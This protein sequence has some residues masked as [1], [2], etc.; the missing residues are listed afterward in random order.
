MTKRLMNLVEKLPIYEDNKKIDA[1]LIVSSINRLY[2]SGFKSS[3]GIIFVTLDESYFVVDFRYY[4]SAL[5]QVKNM[6]VVLATDFKSEILDIIK[7]HGIK[8]ILLENDGITL[9][10]VLKF[11]K[12]VERTSVKFI[13]TKT[14]DDIIY[15][16]RAVKTED[17]IKNIKIA[18]EISERALNKLLPTIK[19]GMTEREIAFNLEILIR[20]EGADAISFDLIVASGKNSAIP[21]A[22]PSNKRVENG[23]FITIDM[24]AVYNGYHSD[25]TRTVA[26]GKVS[27]KKKLIYETVLHAQ[28]KAMKAI[29]PNVFCREVDDIARKFIYENGYEGCF[30]HA[31]GHGVGLEI[32][33][34]PFLS[35]RSE[36]VLKPGM[37]ITVEPGIY[38]K[39]EFGVRIEDM[40]LVTETGCENLTLAS[41]EL[42]IL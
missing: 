17:E 15:S 5:K 2:F 8:N 20:K 30:G 25:M 33:E 21:H 10:E 40:V 19:L 28:N 14:L 41:R 22:E 35:A 42:L 4:E 26:L 39:N 1:A 24:G 34:M 13:K 7:R 32:H 23:D 6:K 18:Q 38:L 11:E 27:E 31:L 12:L 37:I 3:E 29:K 16:L 9:A 36:A